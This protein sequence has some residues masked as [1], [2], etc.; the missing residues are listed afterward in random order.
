[1]P[2]V[3][4]EATPWGQAMSDA[5][6]RNA[7][8][9]EGPTSWSGLARAMA[10]LPGATQTKGSYLSGIKAIRWGKRI[11]SESWAQIAAAALRV[12]RSSLPDSSEGQLSTR[13][14]A[15]GLREALDV[16]AVHKEAID[17]IEARV[18]LLER[19]A[20]GREVPR[21]PDAEREPG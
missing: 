1:M 12:D 9:D 5:F 8:R 11:P 15:R 19:P 7:D 4:D 13:E 10:E 16:I 18:A 6:D 17:G 2:P 20:R 21:S 3:A 14:L